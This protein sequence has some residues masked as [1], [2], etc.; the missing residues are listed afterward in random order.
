M[1][2]ILDDELD[3]IMHA[4]G[5]GDNAVRGDH[6]QIARRG[7]NGS[8]EITPFRAGCRPHLLDHRIAFIERRIDQAAHMIDL[9]GINR[10]AQ[11]PVFIR[12]PLAKAMIRHDRGIRAEKQILF[13]EELIEKLLFA[14]RGWGV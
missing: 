6:R 11:Q 1:D 3:R 10:A 7:E 12:R 8:D 13:G 14:G 5:K 9:V 4:R 2:V